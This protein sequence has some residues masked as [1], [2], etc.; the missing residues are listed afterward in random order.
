M[1]QK[2]KLT[3]VLVIVIAAVIAA[4]AAVVLIRKNTHA[5]APEQTAADLIRDTADLAVAEAYCC[6]LTV[7]GDDNTKLWVCFDEEKQEFVNRVGDEP[8]L[9]GV[10]TLNG[11]EIITTA[12]DEDGNELASIRYILDDRYLLIE[13]GMYSGDIPEGE[14]FDASAEKTDS[15]GMLIRYTF[16]KDGTYT[17]LEVP[18]GKSE[19]EGTVMEGTYKKNGNL[20]ERTLSGNEMIPF[21]VYAGHLFPSY[22]VETEE[23]EFD[24]K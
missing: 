21:Y 11:N 20:I 8:A 24:E 10:Y 9:Q 13:D 1:K 14:T 22:Y 3:I 12:S 15:S 7:Y 6:D 23:P 5:P 16:Q 4:I 19:K 18:A 2:K 17:C